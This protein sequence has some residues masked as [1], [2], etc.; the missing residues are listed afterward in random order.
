MVIGWLVNWYDLPDVCLYI[1][2]RLKWSA[3]IYLQDGAPAEHWGAHEHHA[4]AWHCSRRGIVNIVWLKNHLAV[5]SH[6]YTVSI[7]QGKSSVIVQNWV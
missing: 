4:I 7:C 2:E 3:F 6:W 1:V 5:G